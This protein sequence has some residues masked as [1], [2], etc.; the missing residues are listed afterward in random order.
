MKRL[1]AICAALTVTL[2]GEVSAATALETKAVLQQVTTTTTSAQARAT[3]PCRGWQYQAEHATPYTT[4]VRRMK[5]LI[6]CVFTF[7]GIPGQVATA[8][9]IA[10]RESG[11]SPWARNPDVSSACRW[12]EPFGSCGIF[13]HVMR[14]WPGRVRALLPREFFPQWP[15]VSALNERANVWVTARLVKKDG[16]CHWTPPYSCREVPV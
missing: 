10:D 12:R 14:Y 8:F 4:K 1:I 5:R 9:P 13:Q 16:W 3:G 2:A 11:F 15:R 7:N 6:R